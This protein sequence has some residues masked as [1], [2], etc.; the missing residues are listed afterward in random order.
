MRAFQKTVLLAL[1]IALAACASGSNAIL[2]TL[3]NVWGDGGDVAGPSLN[4]NLTYLR[5]SIQGRAVFLALGYTDAHPQGPIEVWY[6]AEK[7]TLR[8]QNGRVI[9]AA[10]VVTEWRSVSL[11]ALPSWAVM[12]KTS[13]PLRW[14]RT[15]DLMPG[16]RFGVKDNLI[17]YPI[18][19][20][21]KSQLLGIDP[22]SLAW[23]EERE[24]SIDRTAS[25]FK[26]ASGARDTL[27]PARYA[28]A[29]GNGTESVVYA[30]QCLAPE[31]C[32]SWQRWPAVVAGAR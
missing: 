26:P 7:E 17:T 5:V 2:Q 8:I 21:G 23:F 6:S 20:P 28:V 31:L 9:G 10:G 32:F 14:V 1:L 16:Y 25:Q 13:A 4:P 12:A 27:P 18:S 19:P 29:I 15:R 24:D 30:E 22:Q 3:H 11:P